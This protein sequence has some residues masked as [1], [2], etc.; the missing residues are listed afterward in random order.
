MTAPSLLL[1]AIL[2]LSSIATAGA[3]EA[4]TV[5]ISTLEDGVVEVTEQQANV[6]RSGEDAYKVIHSDEAVNRRNSM[7]PRE[8]QSGNANFKRFCSKYLSITPYAAT[9]TKTVT[10]KRGTTITHK[11]KTVV[12]RTISTETHVITT[13]PTITEYVTETST[14]IATTA[15]IPRPEPDQPTYINNLLHEDQDQ[16]S[17]SSQYLYN[18][19]A[20]T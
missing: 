10:A 3:T 11:I 19:T 4:A 13:R 16:L 14:H 1:I 20:C 7:S 17:H 2:R 6:I 18:N 9:E 12:T 8:R 5:T 15:G